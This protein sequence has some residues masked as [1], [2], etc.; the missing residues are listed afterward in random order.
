MKKSS[1]YQKPD[2]LTYR[3]TQLASDVL[4]A[5]V[6]GRR[7]LRN[8]IRRKK[9]AYVVIAN[10]ECALDFV[11]LIGATG[12]RMS[13]VI[14]NSFF[15]TLPIQGALGKM[16]VI[17]KQQFQ[18]ELSDLKKIKNAIDAGHPVVIYPAGLMTEDGLSTPIPRATYKFLK[19]LGCDVYVARSY[20][21]YFCMPKWTKGMRRGRT[22]I[23]IYKLF[24]KEE[25]ARLTPEEIRAKAEPALL[26]DAY[27][28]QEKLRAR[29]RRMN[30][31]AGLENVLYRCPNCGQEFTVKLEGKDTLRCGACGFAEQADEWGFL[32]KLGEVGTELR[33]VSDWSSGIDLEMKK[34]LAENPGFSLDCP[35]EIRMIDPKKHKFVKAGSGILHFDRTEF[36]LRG[37]LR[38]EPFEL[39]LPNKHI[40]ALPFSPGRYLE[41][42]HGPEIYRCVLSDGRLAM[43][44][45]RALKMNHILTNEEE[46]AK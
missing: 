42:Q 25:T 7:Y 13:F 3:F 15:S 32:H 38:G 33:Y 46:T 37:A 41:L 44:F 5:A 30:E 10:H 2:N 8:E 6:F 31:I 43:K 36:T 14:S 9:G 29:F 34:T 26:F 19:W 39:R 4:A 17:P 40:P 12:R 16:S 28:D 23:D 1:T 24:S 45:I 35:T 20:G 21:S 18:T 27:R 22:Y 11:N